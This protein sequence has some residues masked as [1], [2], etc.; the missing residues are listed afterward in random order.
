MGAILFATV[1]SIMYTS[2]LMSWFWESK[3]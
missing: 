2:K 1:N 3:W